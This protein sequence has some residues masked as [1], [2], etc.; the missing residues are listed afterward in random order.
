[1]MTTTSEDKQQEE[2]AIPIFCFRS[3]SVLKCSYHH[4]IHKYALWGLTG[5][6]ETE[7]LIGPNF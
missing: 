4:T 6:K 1:M 5:I 3:L 7:D 2:K